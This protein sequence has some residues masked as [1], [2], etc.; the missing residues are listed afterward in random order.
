MGVALVPEPLMQLSIPGVVYRRLDEMEQ[1]ADLLLVSRND[2]T[3]GAVRAFLRV[4]RGAAARR[5]SGAHS[6]PSHDA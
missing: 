5:Q 1:H 3:G 6:Y 4:A 2:E